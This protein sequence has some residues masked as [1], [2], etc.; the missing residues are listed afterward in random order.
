M[1]DLAFLIRITLL[2][3]GCSLGSKAT[4]CLL[5]SIPVKG[6][7]EKGAG[8]AF[9][10]NRGTALPCYSK[11]VPAPSQIILPKKDRIKIKT[12]SSQLEK[13]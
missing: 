9:Y 6:I 1:Q 4:S 12:E 7:E 3:I 10:C 13:L 5:D 8:V 11:S 2:D